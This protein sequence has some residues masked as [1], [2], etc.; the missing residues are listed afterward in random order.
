MNVAYHDRIE[1]DEGKVEQQ[2]WSK[3]H[4]RDQQVECHEGDCRYEIA[5]LDERRCVSRK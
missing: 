3:D 4:C 2:S 5:Y 1:R